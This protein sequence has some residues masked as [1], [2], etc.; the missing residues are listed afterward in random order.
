MSETGSNFDFLRDEW[1]GLY[2]SARQV[3]G[4]AKADPRTSCFYARRTLEGLVRWLYDHDGAFRLPYDTSLN[5]LLSD[6]SFKRNVPQGIVLKAELIRKQ[7]N[8]AVHDQRPVRD[9]DAVAVLQDLF[10]IAYWLVRTYRRDLQAPLQEMFD[11]YL[12]PP[13]ADDVA[14]QSRKQLEAS[15]SSRPSAGN[16]S[17]SG[18]L[19][20]PCARS[21]R[22]SSPTSR[23]KSSGSK[24]ETS[25]PPTATTTTRRRPARPS[26]T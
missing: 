26:S 14:R 1:A 22:R 3:E 15:K 21:T 25:A 24:P 9:T 6:G 20:R 2:A 23:P 11:P 8:R 7:G 19:T 4:Y 12:L 13:P 18:R 16:V 5:T 10:Q 17:R